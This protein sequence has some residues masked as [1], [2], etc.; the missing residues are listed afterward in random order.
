[1]YGIGKAAL[2]RFTKDAARPLAAHGV[3][4]VSVRPSP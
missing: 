1:V 2:D 3:A 4:I